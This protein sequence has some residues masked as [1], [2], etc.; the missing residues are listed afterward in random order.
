[1]I[2]LVAQSATALAAGGEMLQID[3]ACVVAQRAA[4]HPF[5]L[6]WVKARMVINP[7]SE[8]AIQSIVMAQ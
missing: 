4:V 7:A 2:I 1:M 5:L 6:S 8:C 3:F